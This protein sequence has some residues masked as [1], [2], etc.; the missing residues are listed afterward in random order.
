MK[1]FK[2][3]L[4]KL[5][6]CLQ[7]AIIIDIGVNILILSHSL[8][9]K[10]HFNQEIASENCVQENG[11]GPLPKQFTL[12]HIIFNLERSIHCSIQYIFIDFAAQNKCENIRLPLFLEI[13]KDKKIFVG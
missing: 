2:T 10:I 8:R 11:I 12:Q 5:K 4:K 3:L 6:F 7:L 9:K 13:K 1:I